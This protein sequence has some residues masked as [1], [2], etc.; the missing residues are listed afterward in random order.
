MRDRGT[1]MRDQVVQEVELFR[2]QVNQLPGF[3]YQ[4]F[5]GMKLDIAHSDSFVVLMRRNA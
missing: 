2:G 4:P 5:T 3:S 1:G